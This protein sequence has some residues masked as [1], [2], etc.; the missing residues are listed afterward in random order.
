MLTVYD[1][2]SAICR[3]YGVTIDRVYIVGSGPKCAIQILHIKPNTHKISKNITLKYISISSIINIF[4]SQIDKN[5]QNDGDAI[6]S[7]ICN[8]QKTKNKNN[9]SSTIS[10]LVIRSKKTDGLI[11]NNLSEGQSS[12]SETSPLY[13]ERRYVDKFGISVNNFL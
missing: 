5:I 6:E 1:I 13:S 7:W 10:F 12:Q 4:G 2:T 11:F 9:Y 3:N 8:S